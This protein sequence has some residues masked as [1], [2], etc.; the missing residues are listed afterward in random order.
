MRAKVFR[1]IALI[2]V[3]A[4]SLFAPASWAKTLGISPVYQ[5]TPV[6]CWA[7]VGE[8]VFRHY[9]VPTVNPAG[10]FQCGIVALLHPVCNVNCMN[11]PVPAG[12][13]QTMD[14]MLTRYPDVAGQVRGRDVSISTSVADE[15]L[16][17]DDVIAEIDAGRPI[18]AGISP[19]GYRTLGL[20][21]HVAL[22]IGYDDGA[23]I[24]ND[25]FPFQLAFAGDPYLAAG[26]Q[27]VARG[28][29]VIDYEAFVER[30]QWGES[31]YAIECAGEDCR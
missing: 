20:S 7:A 22:I 2:V 15:A 14:D 13:L 23:L 10:N 30:L 8:M 19:S 29:Y 3:A 26:G 11:C 28:R 5:Q 6:W 12:S 17:L 21:E 25:P 1:P 31:I 27:R 9:G 4:A 16:S 18:V 24:V